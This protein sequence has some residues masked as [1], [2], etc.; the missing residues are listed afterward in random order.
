MYYHKPSSRQTLP[1]LEIPIV[2][3]IRSVSL[4][5]SSCTVCIPM[6]NKRNKKKNASSPC[7]QYHTH[8]PP[9]RYPPLLP[10]PSVSPSSPSY[11]FHHILTIISS[12]PSNHPIPSPISL[13]LQVQL[14]LPI[15][16]NQA[17]IKPSQTQ[18]PSYNPDTCPPNHRTRPAGLPPWRTACTRRARL[19]RPCTRSRA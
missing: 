13:P 5:N 15:K 9:P 19:F 12:Q 8:P 10:P 2:I 16:P 1:F 18:T 11:P 4:I 7:L 17:K 6:A 14:F 3:Y